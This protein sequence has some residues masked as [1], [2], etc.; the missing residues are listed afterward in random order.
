M[1]QEDRK[2]QIIAMGELVWD[3]LPTGKVLGGFPVNLCYGLNCLGDQAEPVTA[4]GT[5]SLGERAITHLHSLG[6]STLYVQTSDHP[7]GT[8]DVSLD[9]RGQPTFTI[10][11]N[12]AWDFLEWAP[13]LQELAHSAD[14]VCFGTL[15]QRSPQSRS[16]IG[17]LLETAPLR[18]LRV[19]DVN[20][21][22]PHFSPD[23]IRASLQK[24]D[25]VKLSD[26]EMEHVV[27]LLEVRPG[28]V[29][30]QMSQLLNDYRLKLICVTRGAEGSILMSR[31]EIHLHPGFAVEVA[32]TVGAGD[33]FLAAL[34]FYYLRQAPLEVI[35]ERAN[36]LGA[37]ISSQAGATP[38]GT[39]AAARTMTR[40]ENLGTE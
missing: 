10:G 15:G 40:Q 11:K 28:P 22:P 36:R 32:D 25:I 26:P 9:V 33:A 37:W 23:I 6:L 29:E 27:Q 7:T 4:A 31:D 5:D 34:V 38:P 19:F 24:A 20:L 39:R 3:M 30:S 17:R 21:R 16:T 13:D 14:A 12:A 2:Y 8:V 18:A 1:L 35:N